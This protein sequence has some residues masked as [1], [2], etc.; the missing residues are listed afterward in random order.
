MSPFTRSSL[1][2]GKIN[3]SNYG[4]NNIDR[5]TGKSSS[6]YN[7]LDLVHKTN[8]SEKDVAYETYKT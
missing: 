1:Y 6:Y 7:F 5:V 2:I 8:Y 3:F 4:N